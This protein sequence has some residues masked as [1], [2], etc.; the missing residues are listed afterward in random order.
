MVKSKT[1]ATKPATKPATTRHKQSTLNDDELPQ[2]P[3]KRSPSPSPN[4]GMI[5][6][7]FHSFQYIMHLEK[8]M[9][10]TPK[11]AGQDTKIKA[12]EKLSS[13]K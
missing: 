9:F 5:Q 7:K 2:N 3:R 1:N 6:S 10:T 12:A 11:K 8:I 4:K 13:A